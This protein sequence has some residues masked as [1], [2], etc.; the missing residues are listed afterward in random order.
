MSQ[1]T[2]RGVTR[3][4]LLQRGGVAAGTLYA[5]TLLGPEIL[6]RA[7]AATSAPTGARE[8]VFASL[9]DA[10]AASPALRLDAAAAADATSRFRARYAALAPDAR[11]GVDAA[12]DALERRSFRAL[13]RGRRLDHLRGTQPALDVA[14]LGFGPQDDDGISHHDPISL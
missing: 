10:V 9:A 2:D 8:Q 3:R 12:L 13:S 6:G 11:A 14:R 5:G 1:S 4:R 7:A